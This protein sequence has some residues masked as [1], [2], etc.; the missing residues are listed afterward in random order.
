MDLLVIAACS[1][2]MIPVVFIPTC[3][4]QVGLALATILLFPGYVLLALVYPKKDTMSGLERTGL[5]ATLS[6]AIVILF[7]FILSILAVGIEVI[8]VLLNVL[9]IA[10]A[11]Y[12]F[13]RRRK[14][15]EADRYELRV[16]WG[17]LQKKGR[18]WE[19]VFIGFAII[20]LLSVIGM[21][22]Q[23]VTFIKMTD[24]FTEF[25]IVENGSAITTSLTVQKNS[26]RN[27]N[28]VL[29]NWEETD[30]EYRVY[31][32]S[33]TGIQASI[34]DYQPGEVIA[35][36]DGARWEKD[37]T[38]QAR[39]SGEGQRITIFL[40]TSETEE[41]RVLSLLLDVTE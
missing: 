30:M 25:Y 36:K 24:R 7:G 2:F 38:L 10:G 32:E 15:P 16:N 37:L 11:G 31:W 20:V 9:V 27:L 39:Q 23:S 3:P 13:Y 35:V 17:F 34:D 12:A 41:Y 40:A 14:I 21:A 26:L 18:K 5:V 1:L 29:V 4:F 19:R 22:A 6:I 8:L 28:L 33:Q